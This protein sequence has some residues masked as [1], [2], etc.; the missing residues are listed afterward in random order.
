M[1]ASRAVGASNA[2]SAYATYGAILGDHAM[3]ALIYM[4]LVAAD[5]DAEPWFGLGL[6]ALSELA[7]GRPVPSEEEDPKGRAA[8]L[9]AMGRA[10]T[11]MQEA[12]AIRTAER[13]RFGSR[14]AQNARYRLYLD[15][16]CPDGKGAPLR[17][18]R[19]LL[20]GKRPMPSDGKRLMAPDAQRPAAGETTGRFVSDHRTKNVCPQD[21]ERP[22]KEEE[23]EEERINDGPVVD[24]TVEDAPAS[25]RLRV[26]EDRSGGRHRRS[27]PRVPGERPII[28]HGLPSAADAIP[29]GDETSGLPPHC[30]HP[31]CDPVTRQ[32][33]SGDGTSICCPDCNPRN[34]EK[35]S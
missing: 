18:W 10:M 31:A 6:E 16:P 14:R 24:G 7:F 30:G 1:R 25:A 26:I 29:A 35:A 27:A 5:R 33:E 11:E 4:A 15:A 23:E 28:P 12:G 17:R 32:R 19:Q 3:R 13:A 22:T 21:A 9:R 8:A 2:I 34:T 20:D